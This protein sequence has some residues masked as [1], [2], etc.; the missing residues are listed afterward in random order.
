MDNLAL[1][2]IAFVQVGNQK[3][4]RE[5]IGQIQNES[6][7]YDRAPKKDAQYAMWQELLIKAN[8]V[9]PK[10]RADRISFLMR[11]VRGMMKT[12]G[13][14]AAP[15]LA[16][17]LIIEA[18]LYNAKAGLEVARILCEENVISGA[19]LT[20]A[21]LL[22][23]V[24][25]RKD[26]AMVCGVTWCF[27]CLP[28]YKTPHY[29]TQNHPDDFIKAVVTLVPEEEISALVEILRVR[30]ESES[31]IEE[32]YAFLQKLYL[33]AKGRGYTHIT[34]T[35]ALQRWR[36]EIPQTES[37]STIYNEEV[38]LSDLKTT[39]EKENTPTE[40]A[41]EIRKTFYQ[42]ESCLN[43]KEACEIFERS[44]VLQKDSRSQFQLIRLALKAG[45]KKY[46][47][48][49]LDKYDIESDEFASWTEGSRGSKLQY[50]RAL[51]EL[52]GPHVHSEA[53]QDFV[54]S[55][56]MDMSAIRGA[57]LNIDEILPLIHPSP[58]W[59]AIWELLAEQLSTTREYAIGQ[60]FEVGSTGTEEEVIAALFQEAATIPLPELQQHFKMGAFELL[61]TLSGKTVFQ[62]LVNMLLS[63]IKEEPAQGLTLLLYDDQDTFSTHF[64]KKVAT[65][66][67][68]PDYAVAEMASFLSKRWKQKVVIIENELPPLY[69]LTLLSPTEDNIKAELVIDCFDELID[70]F[71][72]LIIDKL[73]RSPITAN[74]INL[75]VHRLLQEWSKSN[76]LGKID[77]VSLENKLNCLKMRM[78]YW[79]PAFIAIGRALR[80]VA[81]ELRQAG[82]ISADETSELL[83]KMNYSVS[84]LVPMIATIRP[85]FIPRLAPPEKKWADKDQGEKWVNGVD[86][87]IL[88]LGIEKGE[89]V[90]AEITTFEARR[91]HSS[92]YSSERIRAPFLDVGNH[93]EME[94][95]INLFPKAIWRNGSWSQP[96]ESA[97]TIVR[98]ITSIYFPEIPACEF[99]ICPNWLQRLQWHID[100][101]N[102]FIYLDKSEQIVARI[103]WWRDG[104]PID[105]NEDVIWGEGVYLSVTISGI[106]QIEAVLGCCLS[107]TIHANRKYEPARNG[108]RPFAKVISAT[109]LNNFSLTPLPDRINERGCSVSEAQDLT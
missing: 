26:L 97:T 62:E 22:A 1:L 8:T 99:I 63:G 51:I 74:H 45:D 84:P 35:D 15:R 18:T 3:R 89:V 95:W 102:R 87:D 77:P 70:A 108:S 71:A 4:A 36:V 20:N 19:G 11:Q 78:S 80:Y 17:P 21:L 72:F 56:L 105:N 30:I 88:Q 93:I 65:L 101:K 38:N 66:A 54:N 76:L 57:N 16:S 44:M 91:V 28:Y 12:E 33:A 103:V 60:S 31:V 52:E 43:F 86:E 53:Y 100:P 42:L 24:K 46:A 47:R 82:M 55:M 34:L 32:R 69:N 10:H 92:C 39:L 106:A 27:L 49:L 7:G 59:P 85:P 96:K 73:V 25:R 75:K 29:F 79:K 9:D 50:F 67:N 104:G 48:S 41:A 5:L 40:N 107:I 37:S 61:T 14:L 6:L 90:I 109:D 94:N 58:D 98:S 23:I 81:G 68:H 2:A 64:K 13:R 83:Y